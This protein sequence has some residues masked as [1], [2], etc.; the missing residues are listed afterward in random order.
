[1]SDTTTEDVAIQATREL[2]Q[3][4]SSR[5]THA[6]CLLMLDPSLRPVDTNDAPWQHYANCP[7]HPVPVAHA[8]VEPAHYPVL[9]ALDLKVD[10]DASLLAHSVHEAYIELLPTSLQQGD[11]RRIS[12]WLVSNAP[13]D[14]VVLHLGQIMVQRHP[15]GG[16]VWLRLQ[17]PAVFWLV[18]GWSQPAQRATLLGPIENLYL[19]NPAGELQRMNAEEHPAGTNLDLSPAQWA[20]I[21]CIEPLNAAL[22][23][24][25]G[26]RHP[27]QLRPARGTALAAIQRAKR[28]GFNNAADL[29][30]YALCS[31]DV[32]PRFDFHSLVIARLRARTPL[33]YFGNLVADLEAKDWQRIAKEAPPPKAA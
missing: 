24:W 20:A 15:S 31:L 3:D 8:N 1:M 17:D 6:H 9:T 14:D 11:G 29:A 7:H 33:D 25:K 30:F 22:R 16:H 28:L 19:V 4:I 13:A 21:D 18:W 12:G 27:D 2:L 10:S 5:N 32:H 26:L 23:Q